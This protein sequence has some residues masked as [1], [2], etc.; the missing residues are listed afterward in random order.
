MV[1]NILD[2]KVS[3]GGISLLDG[4][5]ITGAKVA[6]EKVLKLTPIGDATLLSASTKI[7]GSVVTSMLSKNKYVQYV[8][9]GMLIDG[10]EDGLYALQSMKYG[11]K[12]QNQGVI[13]I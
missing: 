5:Y 11:Q 13:T 8:S 4:F 6:V 3:T 2:T 7:A 12:A 1:K 10:V 9:I